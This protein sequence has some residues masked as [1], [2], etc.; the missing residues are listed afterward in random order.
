MA[1][2]ALL[3]SSV[4]EIQH[5][6]YFSL[7]QLVVIII[8]ARAVGNLA[9]RVGQPRVVGEMVAGLILGPSF[10]GYV[11]PDISHYFFHSVSSTPLNIISQIGLLFL[12]FQIGME[13]DFSHLGEKKNRAAVQTIAA[14]SILLPFTLGFVFGQSSAPTLAPDVHPQPYSLFVGIA[15]AITAVP[16]LGRIM[17]E[18]SLTRTRVGAIT[19]SAAAVNDVVGWLL[20]AMIS[21]L[22]TAQLSVIA[23]VVQ[24]SWVLIYLAILW[25][26][27]RPFLRRIIQSSHLGQDRLPPNLVAITMII[28]FISGMCTLSIGIFPFF[29]A[30]MV[31]VL[32][33]D[34]TRFVVLWKRNIGDFVLVFF[35]PIFFTYTGLRTNIFGLDTLDLWIWCLIIVLAA[36]L[37]KFG[38]GY[39]AA[40]LTGLDHHHA[41]AIGIMMNTRGLM[42]LIVLNIGFDLGVL[43]Q[44]VFTMLVIMAVVTTFLTAVAL[45]SALPKMGHAVTRGIDA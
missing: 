15:L 33:H 10:F 26:L 22:A 2:S 9:K 24:L 12:M 13:F 28:V 18:F 34:Q 42:E 30:F 38:G 7:L 32:V 45:R 35:L 31:G 39:V 17:M 40:R 44:R 16:V 25:W 43:P 19:I 41:I 5:M 14:F 27:V 4:H 3:V 21:A 1:N 20:L 23:T 8:T 36:T 6:L 37:G 11:F 29:G